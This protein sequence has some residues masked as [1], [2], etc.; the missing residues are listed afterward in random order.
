MMAT[1]W[2]MNLTAR[3]TRAPLCRL[4]ALLA[5]APSFCAGCSLSAQA[6][7]AAGSGGSGGNGGAGGFGAVSGTGGTVGSGG[8]SFRDFCPGDPL[9]PL[10]GKVDG[11]TF[12]LNDDFD[13]YCGGTGSGRDAVYHVAPEGIGTLRVYL[14]ALTPGF[15]PVLH[16]RRACNDGAS[17][18]ACRD[19]TASPG[20]LTLPTGSYFLIVDS[21]D[22][23]VGDYHLEVLRDPPACGDGVVNEG[24]E[25]DRGP[26]VAGD[27]CSPSCT[28]EFV[29]TT[30]DTCPGPSATVFSGTPIVVSGYSLGYANDYAAPC[31]ALEGAPDRVFA[32]T[33]QVSGTLDVS[34]TPV[35]ASFDAVLSVYSTCK[36]GAALD[37]L[38]ACSDVDAPRDAEHVSVPV[39]MNSLYYVVVD[40]YGDPQRVGDLPNSGAFE[41]TV[42]LEP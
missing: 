11:T 24:E 22:G 35:N 28:L 25:C 32:F 12:G 17:A 37:G 1:V 10:V 15:R 20:P 13:P 34:L 41:L 3:P 19:V 23:T 8:I 2:P 27:G 33:P 31:G 40:G 21:R 7:S 36:V 6:D 18:V 16:A 9:P 39:V 29:E 38:L 42:R 4:L 5:L 14:T 30:A 26:D